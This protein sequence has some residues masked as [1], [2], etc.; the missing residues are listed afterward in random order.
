MKKGSKMTEEQR[1]KLSE[2]HKGKIAWNKGIKG[3]QLPWNKGKKG[4]YKSHRK[5]INL[6]Q[7]YGEE[8]ANKIRRKISLVGKGRIPWNKGKTAS[9]ETKRKLSESHKGQ[10]AWN[11]GRKG[12]SSEETKQKMSE[13]QKKRFEKEIVWNKGKTAS[14]ETKRKLSESHKGQ[15]AWNKGLTKETDKRIKELSEKHKRILIEINTGRKVSEESKREISKSNKGRKR[16]EESKGKM[17]KSQKKLWAN[18]KHKKRMSELAKR[19]FAEHPE[20][21]KRMSEFAKNMMSIPENRERVRQY[22]LKQYDSG[23]FPKQ[24]DTKPERQIKEELIKR[25]YVEGINF[26]HQY[27]FMDKFMCDFCFPNKKVIVEVDGDF[28]HANPKRY[29]ERSKMHKH[30]IKGIN[31]DKSKNAYIG[32]VDNGSWKLIR[33]WESDIKRNVSECVDKIEQS[34]KD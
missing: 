18:P 6:E 22:I 7:E 32:K 8:K 20:A 17:S 21:I 26:V 14:E 28:W 34:L 33:L 15:V 4:L 31:R 1:K 23:S 2:A 3:V 9:E 25:G 24:V 30:Q 12:I 10:V 29:P 27:K 11:K 19:Y 5:G 16:S 13:S